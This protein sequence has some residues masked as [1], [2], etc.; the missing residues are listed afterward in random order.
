MKLLTTAVCIAPVSCG[1]LYGPTENAKAAD[2]A[3]RKH[4]G[5]G[6]KGGPK[7]PTRCTTEAL[8]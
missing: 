3:A 7:H 8:R 2:D 4:T 6:I 1:V 5:D